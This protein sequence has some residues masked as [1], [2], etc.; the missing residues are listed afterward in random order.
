MR[1]GDHVRKSGSWSGLG[2]A[3]LATALSLLSGGGAACG[4]APMKKRSP[5]APEAGPAASVT[6]GPPASIDT[7][8]LPIAEADP[9]RPVI[10]PAER[11]ALAKVSTEYVAW[12]EQVFLEDLVISL[13]GV[14]VKQDIDGR[15]VLL[16]DLRLRIERDGK[17]EEQVESFR[18]ED[19]PPAVFAGHLVVVR[20]GSKQAV[21]V[22]VLRR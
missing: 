8:A 9:E 22:A 5:E 1:G 19:S 7:P 13:A 18:G 21:G 20:G 4:G 12:G 6:P 10:T 16:A 11:A 15:E 2:I 14:E 17:I 3:W